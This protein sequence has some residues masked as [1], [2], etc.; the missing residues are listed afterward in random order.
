[1]CYGRFA[2]MV[3]ILVGIADTVTRAVCS[4]ILMHSFSLA[5]T[6]T[7][8]GLP[9]CS[10]HWGFPTPVETIPFER[11]GEAVQFS[12]FTILCLDNWLACGCQSYPYP[13]S[14]MCLN[15]PGWRSSNATSSS[16]VKTHQS[17]YRRRF[18]LILISLQLTADTCWFLWC[19]K[20]DLLR[21]PMVTLASIPT[22]CMYG[23]LVDW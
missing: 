18:I 19:F 16:T 8:R 7:K 23:N 5:L 17:V 13:N 1:M 14:Q 4:I 6:S 3:Q 20:S 11:R 12:S 21:I 2:T 15:W 9:F 22:L 10:R